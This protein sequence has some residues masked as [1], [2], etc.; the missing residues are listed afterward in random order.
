MLQ[1]FISAKKPWEM[2]RNGGLT[3]RHAGLTKKKWWFYWNIM[4]R[5]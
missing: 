4:G 2:D 1:P 5:S 3:M